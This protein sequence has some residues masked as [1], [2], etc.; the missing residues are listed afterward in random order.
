M[1]C[2]FG[3]HLYYAREFGARIVGVDF[4]D[5][6]FSAMRILRGN[7]GASLV[8]GGY[9]PP[10]V[11]ARKFRLHFLFGRATSS[12]RSRGRVSRVAPLSLKKDGA[13]FIWVYSKKGVF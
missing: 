10:V 9:L 1:A 13:V 12:P 11:Q 6:I 4:S 5:A 3:Q 7:A 8:K 2:G